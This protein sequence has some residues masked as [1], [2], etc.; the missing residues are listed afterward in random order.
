MKL[1]PLLVYTVLRLLAFIVPLAILWLFP[2]FREYWWLAAL[3]A[4]LIGMSI[5]LLFLRAPL[6]R[7]SRD[8]YAKRHGSRDDEDVEDA[9]TDQ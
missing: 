7:A 1:P 8:I 3:F 4:A 2:I 9:A 6:S 5:S